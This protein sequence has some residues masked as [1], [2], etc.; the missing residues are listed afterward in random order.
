M[1]YGIGKQVEV[2]DHH[3]GGYVK[4]RGISGFAV[5]AAFVTLAVL[6]LGFGLTL[7]KI[8]AWASPII[9]ACV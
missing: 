9:R 1:K 7:A 8:V 2:Y 3:L 5:A 6:T 4:P